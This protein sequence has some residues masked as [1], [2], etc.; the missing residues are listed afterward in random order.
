MMEELNNVIRE[1][2]DQL[3]SQNIVDSSLHEIETECFDEC[4]RIMREAIHKLESDKGPIPEVD[5]CE[6]QPKDAHNHERNDDPTNGDD[7][8]RQSRQHNRLRPRKAVVY[9]E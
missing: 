5:M 6:T 2:Q 8:V 7:E 3:R 9:K 1:S 4:D